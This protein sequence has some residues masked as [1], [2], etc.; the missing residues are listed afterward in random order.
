MCEDTQNLC[1]TFIYYFKDAYAHLKLFPKQEKYLQPKQFNVN[2]PSTC[3]VC[4]I[5]MHSYIIIVK[6]VVTDNA[7]IEFVKQKSNFCKSKRK[8]EITAKASSGP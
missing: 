5:D 4:Y 1:Q 6:Y 3:F 7:E 2:N 8:I